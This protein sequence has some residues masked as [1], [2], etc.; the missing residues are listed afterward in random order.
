MVNAVS[1]L[2][3][4]DMLGSK[5]TGA[6]ALNLRHT[7]CVSPSTFAVDSILAF[8]DGIIA[9]TAFSQVHLPSWFSHEVAEY[10]HFFGG[11]ICFRKWGR[12]L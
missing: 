5:I 4:E 12:D 9:I 10:F 3:V 7:K 8:V 11:C 6:A 1:A 2:I